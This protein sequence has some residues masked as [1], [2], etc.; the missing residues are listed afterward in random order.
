MQR[1]HGSRDE[2]ILLV[3]LGKNREGRVEMI[4][5]RICR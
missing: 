2:S 5:D 1:V 3:V 4:R